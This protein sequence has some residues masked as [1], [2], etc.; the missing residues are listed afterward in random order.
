MKSI[1]ILFFFISFIGNAQDLGEIRAQYPKAVESTEITEKLYGELAKTGTSS[2][3]VLLA[4][5]GAILTL[6]AKFSKNKRDKKDFFKEGV[7]LLE[8]AIE[9]DSQN[10]EI[11][12]IRL[13]VQENSPKFLGYHKNIE[14][15]K[16]FILKNFGTLSSNTLKTIVKDFVLNSNSYNETEKVGLK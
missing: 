9:L 15:D 13:S 4:Y 1:F 3:S 8:S 14:T 12:Y 10:T 16:D 6:K 5:K 7:S 11:R 2:N